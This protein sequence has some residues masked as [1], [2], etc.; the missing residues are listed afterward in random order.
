MSFPYPARRLFAAPSGQKFEISVVHRD[1]DPLP[2]PQEAFVKAEVARV[3]QFD[4]GFPAVSKMLLAHNLKL[5]GNELRLTCGV[6]ARKYM[7]ATTQPAFV[8]QFGEGSVRKGVSMLAVTITA[9]NKLILGVRTPKTRYP[10]MR[11]CAP[12]GRLAAH[13][14]DPYNGIMAEYREELGMDREDLQSIA[15][16]GVV[17]DLVY[18]SLTYEF[19]FIGKTK[20]TA[21]QVIERA[22]G[23]KSADEHPVLESLMWVPDY[24]CDDILLSEPDAWPPTGF[25]GVAMALEYEFGAGYRIDW[26]PNPM[27]YGNYMGRRGPMVRIK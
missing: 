25:A 5:E 18:G 21:R 17:E 13:E 14:N 11:H 16:I 2:A 22:K 27:L 1:F 15:C 24:I 26:E 8:E 9:D 23:A 3:R 20:L 12:A 6:S 4:P 10:I 19:V 7:Q